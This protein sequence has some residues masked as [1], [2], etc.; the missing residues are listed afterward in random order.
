MNREFTPLTDNDVSRLQEQAR[1]ARTAILTMT[2]LAASGHPGGSMSSIDF[3]LGLYNRANVD[4]KNPRMKDRDRIVVSNGHI[5]PAVYSTLALNGFFDLDAA[6]TEF[7]LAGSMFEGHVEPIVPGIEWGTGNLGQGLSAGVGFA[8]VS[9]LNGIDNHV[10]VLM[11]DGE[12]QKGQIAEARRFAVKYGLTNITAF[13]D[14]NQLQ[15]G[16]DIKHVMPQNIRDGYISDGWDVIEIDGHD[17]REIDHALEDAMN[18]DAPVVII[19]NTIMG[20]G[21]SFMEN[22]AKYHGSPINAEQY[23][24]ACRELGV[25]DRLEYYAGRRKECKPTHGTISHTEVTL[26]EGTP[27]VYDK[28]TDNRSAWGNA[29]ADIAKAN[30]DNNA[31]MAVFDCDLQGSVK[32]GDFENAAP[33]RFF[34]GGIMEHNTATIAGAASTCGIQAYFSDFGVFGVD[35]TYNQHRLNDIN[36][37]NLKLV[38]TH[39]GLDV[40]EDGKT[41]QCVDYLGV[42]RNL[43]HFPVIVPADPNQTDR[44]IRYISSRY[45]NFLVPM[46]R[47]KL[48]PVRDRDGNVLFG[49]DYKF[50]YGKADK[51][52]DGSRAAIMVMGT[53]ADNAVKAADMLHEGGTDVQV[54][55]ISCPCD[56]DEEALKEAAGT[57]MLFTVEDHNVH[58]GLGACVAMKLVD[59]GLRCRL[60]RIGVED[61]CISGSAEDVYRY[62]GLDAQTIADK[63]KDNL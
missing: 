23:A 49:E 28:K 60:I 56:M 8:L 1:T 63:I 33:G 59:M 42:M 36:E 53:P 19:A 51:L 54:W 61:Y 58:T 47:S 25:E 12:Q 20:K 57:G 39:V 27:R 44:V 50:E 35:E 14:Y 30:G 40:G 18:H 34:Q 45:G 32:T 16:G 17:F 10:F 38:T 31:P 37:T 13:I 48:E 62:A 9:R 21:V 2:T 55:N 26:N 5:S 22:L 41:H 29:L 6:V 15:I 4:P 52:R 46:G 24:Q 43:Y 7:R 11:G 3:L